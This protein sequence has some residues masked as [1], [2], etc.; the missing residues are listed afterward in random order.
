M[1][2][3]NARRALAAAG[4][5][6]SQP[7]SVTGF[8]A[9]FEI[10]AAPS[11]VQAWAETV[12]LPTGPLFI[13]IEDMT[14]GG[15]TEAAL[16]LAHRLMADHRADGIY[17]ALPTMATAN[18]M[19]DRIRAAIH[20][21]YAEGTRPSLTLAHGRADLHPA[22]LL[23]FF[24]FS[25]RIAATGIAVAGLGGADEALVRRQLAAGRI[26]LFGAPGTGGAKTLTVHSGPEQRELP[27]YVVE[28]PR[29]YSGCRPG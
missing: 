1:A 18:A 29:A 10:V 11:P 12:T 26:V 7:S 25:L 16:V 5:A 13:L 27:G 15:K 22:F 8:R 28:R 20:R 6:P 4:L 24:D 2:Q 9:L 14:G 21:L 19:F 23:P 3:P 17:F